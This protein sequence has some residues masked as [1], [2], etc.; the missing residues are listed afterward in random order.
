MLLAQDFVQWTDC[1][2]FKIGYAISTSGD[3]IAANE[4]FSILL[5]LDAPFSASA[6]GSW[7]EVNLTPSV[8]PVAAPVRIHTSAWL[9]SPAALSVLSPAVAGGSTIYCSVERR[10]QRIGS[11]RGPLLVAEFRADSQ[12]VAVA[13]L[14]T[15]FAGGIIMEE[16][17]DLKWG[18]TAPPEAAVT[19]YPN[20][21]RDWVCID[22]RLPVD[23]RVRAIDLRGK[24]YSLASPQANGRLDLADLPAGV[25]WLEMTETT[26]GYRTG[27][28]LIHR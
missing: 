15:A 7:W 22:A 16:N 11:G 24:V 3:T 5:Y 25:Y 19:L 28:K 9:G 23:F 6:F 2:G 10:D 13:D 14:V 26:T 12:S 8:V 17:I 20:P 4:Q 18:A 27:C 1:A 21:A